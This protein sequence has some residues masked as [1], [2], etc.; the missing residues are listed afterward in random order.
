MINAL[1]HINSLQEKWKS[2]DIPIDE[3]TTVIVLVEPDSSDQSLKIQYE[4]FLQSV[5]LR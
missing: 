2:S 4:I 1:I 5:I 3:E